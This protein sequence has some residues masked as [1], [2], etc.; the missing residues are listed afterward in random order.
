MKIRPL[1]FALMLVPVAF[2]SAIAFERG[3]VER[4]QP[5]KAAP[6]IHMDGLVNETPSAWFVEFTGNPKVEGGTARDLKREQ[7]AFRTNARNAGLEFTERRAFD[8]LWNGLSVSIEPKSLGKLA[9]VPGVKALYPVVQFD[10]P[11]TDTASPDL[12]TALAMTG[13]DVAQSELGYTGAGIKVAVMDTGIDYDHPDLG[14]CFGP[15]CRVAFGYDLVG[16]DYNADPDS[17]SYDPVPHPDDDPDDCQGH[18]THVSGIVGANGTVTGVAPNVTFGAY[19]VFGCEGS[20]DADIMLAAMEMALADGM[21][22]LNMSIGSSFQWPQYPTAV[23]SDRMVNKGMVVVASIGNSGASGPYAAGAPGVGKKVIGVASFENSDLYG[24]YF[25]VDG[26]KIGYNPMSFA[27]PAPTSGTEEIVFVGRGCN[28]DPYLADPAGKVALIERGAC[29]FNEK[30]TNALAAGA[31]AAVVHNNAPGNFNGTLGSY[32]PIT[33][34]SIT[35]ADGLFIRSLEPVDMT[36]TDQKDSF[37]NPLGGLIASSSSYGLAPDLSLKPDIGAPGANIYSTYPLELGGYA[38][39]SGTSMASPHT[40]G[41]VALLLEAKPKTN[42][43][44]V[45]TILQNS[46]DP[47]DWNLLPGYGYYD[48]VHRQGAGLLDIDDAILA[49]TK[50]E[51][52]K[53]ALGESEG[54]PSV[55]WLTI[56]NNGPEAITYD[57]SEEW[58][59]IAT[60]GTFAADL[61]YWLSDG[62]LIFS[63]DSVKVPAGGKAKVKVTFVPPTGPGLSTYGG[64]IALTPQEGGQVYRV[65]YAGFD[66]D[67]QELPVLDANPFGLPWSVGCTV[68]TMEGDDIAAFWVNLGHQVRKFRME[69]FDAH[70]GRAWHRAYDLDYVGRNSAENSFFEFTWDGTTVNGNKVNVVPDGDYVVVISVLKALGDDD[71]PDHWENWTSPVITIERP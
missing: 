12:Y 48:S 27:D 22:V 35:Q 6:T 61:D 30:A 55:H 14:G 66:G 31:T 17:P 28:I 26:Q 16:D 8:T 58:W 60:T 70:S 20:T 33:A 32:V 50:V 44:I 59:A 25:E 52:G 18:G 37:P 24:P 46:A 23:A 29:S 57:L 69:V 3:G 9:R 71:N 53:I 64:Y 7:D 42:S 65:P 15:G 38:T 5:T 67:Y 43:Q 54:G 13:A 40:A 47:A 10:L 68:C 4:I 21:D 2:T 56:E 39:L 41:A 34:V 62:Y 36:W 45:R 63:K 51:P 11:E 1:A 19:R 49:T